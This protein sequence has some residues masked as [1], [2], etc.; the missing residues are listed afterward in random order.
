M[1]VLGEVI[2]DVRPIPPSLEAAFERIT[3]IRT[4]KMCL[5]AFS[6]FGFSLFT[7]PVLGN[8][9]LQQHFHLDA[10]RRGLI[11]TIGAIGVL[12]ALPYM[13]RYYDRLY[14]ADPAK[15]LALIGK[16]I[17]PAAILTPIQ[18]FMPNPVLYAVFSVPNAVLLL[19][20]F[21]MVSPVLQSVAPYRLR[22]LT[23]AVSSLYVFFIG[24]TGGA[25]LSALA[26]RARSGHARRS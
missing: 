18:F 2:E 20:S 15:A 3:R 23:F 16:V 10:F 13:G 21:S 7:G 12:F 14:Q 25:A 11:G 24:A 19:T 1:D 9:F 4:I 17:L 5:I 26:R 6:A 8:L 22:G